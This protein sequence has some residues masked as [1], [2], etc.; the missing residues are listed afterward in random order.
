[1]N[2]ILAGRDYVAVAT[3]QRKRPGVDQ[4]LMVLGQLWVNRK[5]VALGKLFEQRALTQV[6]LGD[7]SVPKAKGI[8]LDNTMPQMHLTE[9]E[10]AQLGTLAAPGWCRPWPR[11][12]RRRPRAAV[13]A[14]AA[15]CQPRPGGGGHRGCRAGAA[16]AGHG[17]VLR[18]D[19]W[20]PGPAA[21]GDGP[22]PA[23]SLRGA[24][25]PD[26]DPVAAA[27]GFLDEILEQDA[28][29]LVARS[30]LNL[31]K[32]NF[33]R[34]HVLS[35]RVDPQDAVLGLSCVPMMVSL[36]IMAQAC[37]ALAGN[38]NVTVVEHVRA[39]D[40]IALDA[41]EVAL[42]VEARL[43]D[44]PSSATRPCCPVRRASWSAASSCSSP[45][46]NCLDWRR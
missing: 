33:L 39:F 15:P 6:P 12:S 27:T 36:E 11:R 7:L 45:S 46:G 34:D 18:H 13:P 37:A 43:V 32:D 31:A 29:H 44:A 38:V 19:A 20:L 21:V 41:G 14:A 42:T 28:E 24:E 23:R 22:L 5:P 3:N 16:P 10:R 35:G 17:R 8:L 9:A 40:W 25:A 2:D 26:L 4:F 30:T 1:V